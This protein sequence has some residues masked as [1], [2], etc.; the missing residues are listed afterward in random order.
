MK[1]VGVV[2]SRQTSPPTHLRFEFH[3][4]D[5]DSIAVGDYVLV[6]S[7]KHDIIARVEE[8]SA[9][10]SL[11]ERP[12]VL[13]EGRIYSL[14]L[15]TPYESRL[16]RSVVAKA[17]ILG[18][19]NVYDIDP[20][21]LPPSP[22]EKVYKIPEELL[23]RVIGL[24][25]KGILLGK[26]WST[27]LRVELDLRKTLRHHIAILGATG[28]GK[29]YACGV[30]VEELL[31]R[32]VAVVI[33]DPHGEYST[34]TIPS[35]KV[36]ELERYGLRPRGFRIKLY[37][38]KPDECPGS[39]RLRVSISDLPS[40]ALA[41]ACNMTDVQEDLVF[42][43]YKRTRFNSLLA[44]EEAIKITASKYGFKDVTLISVLRRLIVLNELGIIGEGFDPHRLVEPG[45]AT[46]LD[47]SCD[48]EERGR[49]VLVGTVLLKLFE[50]RRRGQIPPFVVVIEEAHRF[51]P[52][53]ENPF[54]KRVIRRIAR[55]GRKFGV[56]LV[57]VSQRVVGLD[58]DVISQC[59]TK[60]LL[61]IDSIT[62]LNFLTPLLEHSASAD[63]RML[64]LLPTGVALLTGVSVR[65]PMLVKIRPR[66]SIHGGSGAILGGD[67]G[68]TDRP[69]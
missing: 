28:T 8:L 3:V 53:S 56:G 57:V 51:A 48:M 16:T 7:G 32:G 27:N 34:L 68:D 1:P 12:E 22:G 65:F 11:F 14:K 63:V 64:P 2:V 41:E 4:Q 59:G 58:K 24:S 43:A 40:E 60:I 26:M 5:E 13:I 35:K 19:I 20:P 49:R 61:R 10:N 6:P 18:T 17:R 42:L 39:S 36:H 23:S 9:Y 69:R 31:R 66:M 37:S 54:S 52:Q 29:S 47:L 45:V 15:P 25:E 21:R 50:A 38:P 33:I 44:L 67:I 62:D 55:E 30:I 46:I